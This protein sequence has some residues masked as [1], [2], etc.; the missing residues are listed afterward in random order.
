MAARSSTRNSSPEGE[1]R[2]GSG[3]KVHGRIAG[4][5]DLTVEGRVEG[6]IVL[7]GQLTVAGGGEVSAE[8]VEADEVTVAGVLEGDLRVKGPVRA[9]SGARIRGNVQG[10]SLALEDGAE[11]SGRIDLDFELPAELAGAQPTSAGRG[12]R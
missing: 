4:D 6:D 12:R 11:F 3:A 2:I 10:G 8:T 9:L 7:R 5:G 1:A